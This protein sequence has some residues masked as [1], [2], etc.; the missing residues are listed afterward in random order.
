MNIIDKQIL[1]EHE[2]V[3]VV[4][5]LLRSPLIA[6]RAKPGQFVVLMTDES[7]ER[8][9]LTVVEAD[10]EEAYLIFLSALASGAD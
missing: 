7:G 4:R 2:G 1:S 9:P 8:F 10:S 3:R 5:F 6:K